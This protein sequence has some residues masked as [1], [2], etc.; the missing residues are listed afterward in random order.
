MP[1]KKKSRKSRRPVPPPEPAPW[2]IAAEPAPIAQEKSPAPRHGP[3]SGGG[4]RLRGDSRG[5]GAA[6]A[7]KYAFRRS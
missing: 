5:K 2:V 6:Q 4:P 1:A 3:Q 7:R